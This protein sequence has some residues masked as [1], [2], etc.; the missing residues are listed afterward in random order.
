MEVTIL[1]DAFLE[2]TGGY[3]EEAQQISSDLWNGSA[4]FQSGMR[5]GGGGGGG[6]H[7]K[8]GLLHVELNAMVTGKKGINRNK[9]KNSK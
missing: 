9:N 4:T 5:G 6:L 2:Q 8:D 3:F 1:S 7:L